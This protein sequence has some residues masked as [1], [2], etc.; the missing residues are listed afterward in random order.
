M[1]LQSLEPFGA[2]Y[3][4]GSLWAMVSWEKLGARAS[5][6]FLEVEG[7]RGTVRGDGRPR[8]RA[9]ARSPQLMKRSVLT[10]VGELDPRM[11]ALWKGNGSKPSCCAEG[12]GCHPLLCLK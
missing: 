2:S 4:L 11:R 3:L 10:N 5:A 6:G 8:L 7:L 12:R 9:T 1:E